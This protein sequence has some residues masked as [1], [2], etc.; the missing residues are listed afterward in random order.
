MHSVTL[1]FRWRSFV[2]VAVALSFLLAAVSGIALFVRPEGS[3]AR[4]VGWSLLGADKK[5]WE[6]LHTA[7][8]L[9]FVVLSVVHV[10][11]N[12]RPLVA[13]LVTR[14]HSPGGWFRR[15]VAAALLL[16]ALVAV[17]S[18]AAWQPFT[19][20]MDLRGSIKDGKFVVRTPPP[21]FDADTLT[22]DDVCATMALAPAEAA[23]NARAR[24]VVI[25]DTSKTLGAV[26]K[27]LRL[28]PEAVFE[29]L[30]GTANVKP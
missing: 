20:V 14:R 30:T 26:A 13:H 17:G 18:L 10:W 21:A 29:A 19:A 24:G 15:E 22:V 8:V 1:P 3:L 11:Y 4:W 28:T 12:G 16:V 2:S 25:A 23:A 27:E 7:T 5:Q 6:S 9:V